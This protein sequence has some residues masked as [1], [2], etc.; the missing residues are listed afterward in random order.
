[1][2]CGDSGVSEWPSRNAPG[3]PRK[4]WKDHGGIDP[5]PGVQ[6]RPA[7]DKI[8]KL[9]DTNG[10]GVMDKKE[11]FYEGLDLVTGLVFHKDGVIVTQAPDILW[12]RDTNNDGKADKIEKLYTGLGTGDTHAVINN[13]RWGWDGWIYAT[14][15][16]SASN[17]VMNAKGETMP[18]IGSGV[19]RFKPDGSA[20]EQYS[21]KGGNTWGLQVTADNRVMWTQPTSGE[22]LMHTVLPEY[23]LARGKVGKQASYKVVEPSKKT[24]PALTWEQM[25][26]VQIDWVGSFTA[27]A[28]TVVYDGGSWPSEYNGDYFTTEPTINI[29]HH[30]RLTPEGS[31]YTFN[32]LPGREETE[33]IAAKT[34]GG[35]RSKRGSVPMAQCISATFTTRPS[36]ITTPVDRITIG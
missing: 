20:I 27:A 13:P 28:G 3:L 36:F 21:S 29:V 5:T 4:E 33:F 32:K 8:S 11:V 1:V 26:Y 25:A 30:A 6:D 15:G 18:A 2:G 9:I 23:A 22:L 34:C 35:G 16:Y 31:S 24:F 12:L 19:V 14:H 7:Q 17:R 10:D